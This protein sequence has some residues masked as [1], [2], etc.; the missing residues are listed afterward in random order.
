MRP[1]V[2]EERAGG[3]AVHWLGRVPYR[4]AWDRQKALVRARI[5]GEIPDQLMLLEHP[6]VITLGR[7]ADEG[8]VRATEEFLVA[9]GVELHRVERGGEVT[10]HG[11]GQLVV[12]P[13]VRLADHDLLVISFVRLLERAMAETAAEYGVTAGRR[14]GYPGCWCDPDGPRPRKIGALGVRVERGVSYHGIALNIT[15]D[16]AGFN[17]INPCGIP[18]VT[19]TSIAR[20][21]GWPPE[22]S[23]PTTESVEEAAGRFAGIF[24]RLLDQVDTARVTEAVK[25]S[26]GETAAAAVR[27][28][29]AVERGPLLPASA[30]A[31]G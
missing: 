13:I 12:Y 21:A 18:D 29:A 22:R 11:P 5:A 30:T 3:L 24:A 6:P 28:T 27:V 14:R 31:G 10:Y 25:V 23:L 4:E 15:T 20:E 1:L 2:R 16:L 7:H 8:N 9:V 26:A 19:V 17:L